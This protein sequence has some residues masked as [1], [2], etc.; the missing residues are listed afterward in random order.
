[1]K[2]ADG[3]VVWSVCACSHE[4]KCKCV[5]LCKEKIPPM[6]VVVLVVTACLHARMMG[7][8]LMAH[9]PPAIFFP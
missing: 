4:S 9:S 1:M 8:G 2:R 7:E 5:H 6:A 3:Q